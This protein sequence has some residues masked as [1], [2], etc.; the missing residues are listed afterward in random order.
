M[1]LDWATRR[2]WRDGTER[3]LPPKPFRLLDVLVRHPG[4]TLTAAMITR[5]VWDTATPP[6]PKVIAVYIHH[7]RQALDDPAPDRLIQT[8]RGVGYRFV[9]DQ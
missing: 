2:V 4:Q 9:A 7:L 5:A 6:Q 3:P 8:M 1:R